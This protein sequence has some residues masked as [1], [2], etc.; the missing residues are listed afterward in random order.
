MSSPGHTQAQ[1]MFL[2]KL[3]KGLNLCDI[4]RPCD[5]SR[6]NVTLRVVSDASEAE[7][8]NLRRV[9]AVIGQLTL[10]SHIECLQ[11]RD[12]EA[13]QWLS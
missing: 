7:F 2:S 11:S 6:L 3:H 4:S 9:S 1:V 5:E 13:I 10:S 12:P 8:G